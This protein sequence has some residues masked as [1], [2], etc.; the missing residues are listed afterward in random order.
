MATILKDKR[1]Y[2]LLTAN[3]FS[4]V[5]SGMT[6]IAI[7]WLMINR[8]NGEQVFGYAS[9]FITILLF[10]VTPY[11]GILIDRFSRKKALLLCE[12]SGFLIVFIFSLWGFLGGHYETWQLMVL[13]LSGTFY[14]T[15]NFPFKF[16][17]NQEIFEPS[18]YKTLN[19]VIEIQTQASSM[20][21]GGIASLLIE[22]ID[23]SMLLLL[24][25]IAYLLAFL[26]IWFVPYQQKNE[27]FAR[28]K[29]NM[30]FDMKEGFH[31]LKERPLQILFLTCS[32]L[33]FVSVMVGNYLF[34]V[35]ISKTLQA[36]ATILGQSFMVY[37]MGAVLAGF[38]I[39]FIMNRFGHYRTVMITVVIFTT[40]ILVIAWLPIV[41]I[42]LLLQFALGWGNA[43]TRVARNTIMMDMVPNQIIGRIDSFFNTVG[44]GIR[45]SLIGLITQT[46][47]I[48]GVSL[49]L[50][51]LG[52]LLVMSF[53]GLLLSRKLF[54]NSNL[55]S[56]H[57]T[58]GIGR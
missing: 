10:F 25:A 28:R 37:A 8:A 6:M 40:G 18:H 22:K 53:V 36:N 13:F 44:L 55:N 14:F 56:L 9:L 33:P 50:S 52:F 46:I 49:P 35:Y 7:P 5:G 42:Y 12:V 27:S 38:T 11:I 34:P 48:T 2:A 19:S 31:Y 15:L 24:N 51:V 29:I 20:L 1:L 17:F 54:I 26:L 43:G 4:S 39:P 41:N 47:H 57:I 58:K 3:I 21:S 16:A 30:W 23:L 45:V 32:F